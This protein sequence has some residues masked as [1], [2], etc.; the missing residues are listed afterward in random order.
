[1]EGMLNPILYLDRKTTKYGRQL[2]YYRKN[3]LLGRRRSLLIEEP[4]KGEE[5]PTE[6]DNALALHHSLY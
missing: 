5:P 6:D 1:M 4:P 2:T 3:Y